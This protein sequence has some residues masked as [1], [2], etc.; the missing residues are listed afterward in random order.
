ML[1]GYP[2]PV[3]VGT[4]SCFHFLFWKRD[5]KDITRSVD[6]ARVCLCISCLGNGRAKHTLESIGLFGLN[7]KQE[8]YHEGEMERQD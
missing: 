4:S 7:V 8:V 2:V 1:F 3:E 6:I 5:K